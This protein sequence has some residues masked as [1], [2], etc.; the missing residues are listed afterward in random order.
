MNDHLL[1]MEL[2]GKIQLLKRAI[3]WRRSVRP[4]WRNARYPANSCFQ[5]PKRGKEPNLRVSLLKAKFSN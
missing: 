4:A 5:C 1:V 3:D 2:A